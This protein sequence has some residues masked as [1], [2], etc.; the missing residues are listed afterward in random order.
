M[1]YRSVAFL[2]CIML[3]S[4]SFTIS[5][6]G[7]VAH[8]KLDGNAKDSVGGHDGTPQGGAE[9][10]GNG[11]NGGAVAL[12][13]NGDYI[14]TD[15]IEELQIAENFTIAAWFKTNIT[16]DGQQMILWVGDVAG[17][18][19]GEQE[20]VHLGINHFNYFDKLVFF[21]GSGTDTD[22]H[23]INIVT[24]A[25]FTDT[26]DWHHIAGVIENA[27]GPIVS[28]KLY[29]DGELMDPL[30]DDFKNTSNNLA[31]PTMDTTEDPP[32]RGA[33]NSGLRIGA[34]GAVQRYFNGMVDDVMVWDEALSQD[35][36][37]TVSGL[38]VE[39]TDKLASV[40]GG[41]KAR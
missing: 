40:W 31:F 27:D 15:L 34:P 16:A 5:E 38:A 12:S 14:Q 2:L 6:A 41:I 39:P 25:D 18:G 26:S 23:C 9:F 28:G 8:W 33:W 29:L 30:V 17:N 37:F 10:K 3:L 11:N 22:G 13:G 32:T 24:K 35:D 36:L 7:L 1:G 4:F 20:E 21:Y 19:W